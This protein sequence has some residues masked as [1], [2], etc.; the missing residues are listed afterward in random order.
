MKHDKVIQNWK[1]EHFIA[2][3]YL[4]V[5][6]ADSVTTDEEIAMAHRKAK[7]IF[8][9]YYK[10]GHLDHDIVVDEVVSEIKSHSD[11]EKTDLIIAMNKK[12]KLT[13]DE[14][15]DII[16]DLTDIIEIDESVAGSEHNMLQFIRLTLSKN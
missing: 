10:E 11:Q 9:E 4:A 12:I 1:E 16:S 7:K 6:S 2:Y 3:L 13:E 15:M 5:A 8:D 14:R